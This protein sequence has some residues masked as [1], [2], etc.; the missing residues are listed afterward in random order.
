CNT[1]TDMSTFCPWMWTPHFPAGNS[2]AA[3]LCAFV[4]PISTF[5]CPSDGTILGGPG[6]PLDP[7]PNPYDGSQR[8]SSTNY[9]MC[10]G[11]V[12]TN[13]TSYEGRGAFT[14]EMRVSR[15]IASFADGMS[16]TIALS[17][18]VIGDPGRARNVRGGIALIDYR[19][20]GTFGE[21]SPVPSLVFASVAGRSYADGVRVAGVDTDPL[22]MSGSRYCDSAGMYSGF[23]TFMPPNGPSFQY[24]NTDGGQMGD[25]NNYGTTAANSNHTGGVNACMADGSVQF[26][27]DSI[28]TG[29]LRND[30]TVRQVM[31]RSGGN[32]NRPQDYGGPSPYGVWGALGTVAAGD[33]S[34]I[35]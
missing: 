11:D 27:S 21:L 24:L 17:E 2:G 34:R 23:H 35:P 12:T 4:S 14:N 31:A 30:T 22:N 26:F 13:W 18:A 20:G 29:E 7:C 5:H 16:N 10:W 28:D 3:L 15:K 1:G 9:R 32:V 8:N 33:M 6:R 19:D 25:R